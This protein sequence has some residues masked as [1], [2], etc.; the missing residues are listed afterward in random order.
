MRMTV[1]ITRDDK[2]SATLKRGD[3]S[4]PSEIKNVL[5]VFP[6]LWLLHLLEI[7]LERQKQ[8]CWNNLWPFV[9]CTSPGYGVH[10]R[11]SAHNDTHKRMH[12]LEISFVHLYT[13]THTYSYFRIGQ[14]YFSC[15]VGPSGRQNCCVSINCKS[16]GDPLQDSSPPTQQPITICLFLSYQR[17]KILLPRAFWATT[18]LASSTNCV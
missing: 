4:K 14:V 3:V 10:T 7:R 11:T 5:G 16:R 18:M 12:W 8:L 2:V 9:S 13:H 1:F 6:H 17:A 15:T